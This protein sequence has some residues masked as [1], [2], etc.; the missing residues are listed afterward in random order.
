M[1]PAL[2]ESTRRLS[3]SRN[4]GRVM[5]ELA[6]LLR[7]RLTVPHIYLKPRIPGPTGIDVLAVDHAGS[8]DVHGVL[9]SR[10]PIQPSRA[11]IREILRTLKTLPVHYRYFAVQTNEA[12]QGSWLLL[13]EL[14]ELFDPS[15]TG[16]VGVITFDERLLAG[17]TESDPALLSVVVRPER[18]LVRG[19]KLTTSERYLDKARPDMQVRI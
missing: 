8:G 14:D 13:R 11:G 12:N 9:T 18:F 4:H 6:G 16:R 5:N 17:N 1:S 7:K 19:E 2:V 10:S 15:G 3:M